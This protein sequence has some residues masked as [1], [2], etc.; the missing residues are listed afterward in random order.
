LLN[1]GLWYLFL[2]IA[3]IP[4]VIL[5]AFA[6]NRIIVAVKGLVGANPRKVSRLEKTLNTALRIAM[7]VGL[8]LLVRA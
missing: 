7:L 3:T 1:Y 8:I 2:L 5:A 4:A 6:R